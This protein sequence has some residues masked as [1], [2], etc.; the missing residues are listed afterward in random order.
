MKLI[1]NPR[2]PAFS[3]RLPPLC[4]FRT[5]KN[6]L[7]CLIRDRLSE[8]SSLSPLSILDAACHAS[9][10]RKM[11]PDSCRYFGLDISLSRLN[12]AS[13]VSISSDRFFHADLIRPL[14]IKDYFD[15]IVSCNTI[16]HIPSEFHSSVLQNLCQMLKPGH[17]LLLNCS[18]DGSHVSIAQH[19]L[20]SFSSI[21]CIYFDSFYSSETEQKSLLGES[22]ITSETIRCE[23]S[24]PNDASL[25]QQLLIHA[26]SLNHTP[27]GINPPPSSADS[28]TSLNSVPHLSSLV[29]SDDDELINHLLNN[30]K[31]S[32][33]FITSKF[34]SSDAG[35]RFCLKLDSLS[36]PFYVLSLGL[37][38]PSH[39]HDFY[40]VGLEKGWS[41]DLA[42]D[43]LSINQLRQKE[44]STNHIVF[45]KERCNIPCK[46][47]VVT[48][49]F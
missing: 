48:F 42:Q 16:S 33:L 13:K 22:N 11:F 34:F 29:V 18:L 8:Y 6:Y 4:T 12:E 38:I 15:L 30:K 26:R 24:I 39:L 47:S 25:H 31:T 35:R 21:E 10:T 28:V 20:N 9:L 45:V 46:P 36:L 43:R 40:Y 5:S 2:K 17:D 27:L 49:D 41:W 19:L 1:L 14:L 3:S 23:S 32:A 37:N 7:W 44:H